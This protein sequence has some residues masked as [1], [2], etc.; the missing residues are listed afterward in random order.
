MRERLDTLERI[1][2]E[3]G[4]VSR[5]DIE[6]YIPDEATEAERRAWRAEYVE[7]IFAELRAEVD[8]AM[9]ESGLASAP[10]LGKPR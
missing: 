7:R 5:A 8:A 3:K 6:A 10:P 2:D 4:S 9:S 1:L